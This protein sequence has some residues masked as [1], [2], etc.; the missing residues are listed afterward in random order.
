MAFLPMKWLRAL[1][2]VSQPDTTLAPP[3]DCDDCRDARAHGRDACAVH[4]AP[5]PRPHTYEMG[6]QVSWSSPLKGTNEEMPIRT[7]VSIH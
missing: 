3:I 2:G 7:S 5:H 6:H 4:G 1:W